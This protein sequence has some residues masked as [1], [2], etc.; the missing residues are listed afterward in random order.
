M[1]LRWSNLTD[2]AVEF[3]ANTPAELVSNGIIALKKYRQHK[4]R[5]IHRGEIHKTQD[6]YES[7]YIHVL[8][9]ADRWTD[10]CKLIQ[11]HLGTGAS[12]RSYSLPGGYFDTD[13]LGLLLARDEI[14]LTADSDELFDWLKKALAW[15]GAID[16]FVHNDLPELLDDGENDKNE[17]C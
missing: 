3:Y 1:K 9:S 14:A 4:Y 15:S 6:L 12:Y 2:Y 17:N 13:K 8:I 11:N 5:R 7:A 16:D 10:G